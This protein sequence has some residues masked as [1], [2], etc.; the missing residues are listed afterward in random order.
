MDVGSAMIDKGRLNRSFV[1]AV[2]SQPQPTTRKLVIYQFS[3]IARFISDVM[4]AA[5]KKVKI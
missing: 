3:K 5:Y 4:P 2:S 1:V